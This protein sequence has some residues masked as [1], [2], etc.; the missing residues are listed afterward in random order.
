MSGIQFYHDDLVVN[1]FLYKTAQDSSS[2]ISAISTYFLN[3]IKTESIVNLLAPGVVFNIL[4]KGLGLTWVGFVLSVAI[5]VFH[6]DVYA[7]LQSIYNQIKPSIENNSKLSSDQ[8]HNIVKSSVENS[9]Q[10]TS[11]SKAAEVRQAILFKIALEDYQINKNAQVFGKAPISLL[12]S[13]LSWFFNIALASA[14][15]MFAGDAI[16]KV[17]NKP[18]AFDSSY[19]E[20]KTPPIKEQTAI[21]NSTQTKYPVKSSYIDTKY[22]QGTPWSVNANNS[23]EG[24][25][26]MLVQFAHD[27]YDIKD[28]PNIT[29][30]TAFNVL[31]ARI[32]AFNKSSEGDNLVFIPQYLN[33]K[34]EIVDTFIDEVANSK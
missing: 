32:V 19:K 29:T 3:N 18:N 17:L 34:K 22:N 27:V 1:S 16:N 8:V 4:S 24:I 28:D 12:T 23:P 6:I 26:D 7:I 5:R 20:G 2:L 10:P 30:G 21:I 11:T 9:Y 13:I 14:G 33:S 31:K 15:F 25:E